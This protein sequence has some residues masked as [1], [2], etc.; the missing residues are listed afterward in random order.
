M[1]W[2][3]STTTNNNNQFITL[4]WSPLVFFPKKVACCRLN[5]ELGKSQGLRRACGRKSTMNESMYFLLK[6]GIFQP[7]MLVNSGVHGMLWWLLGFKFCFVP[8]EFNKNILVYAMKHDAV[9]FFL[10]VGLTNQTKDPETGLL[11]FDQT[12]C[13]TQSK[14]IHVPC[15]FEAYGILSPE[16]LIMPESQSFLVLVSNQWDFH[17]WQAIDDFHIGPFS[18]YKQTFG[19]AAQFQM[20]PAVWRIEGGK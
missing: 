15:L 6:M 14:S 19:V 10:E 4:I 5:L 16:I 3:N 11:F 1:G 13:M 8:V 17:R 2:F 9:H 12:Q 20:V 7:V 18:V